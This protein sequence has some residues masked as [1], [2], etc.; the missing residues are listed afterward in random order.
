MNKITDFEKSISG[1]TRTNALGASL[2][3]PYSEF[4]VPQACYDDCGSLVR[5]EVAY[6]FATQGPQPTIERN[7][8]GYPVPRHGLADPV[9]VERFSLERGRLSGEEVARLMRQFRLKI[10]ALSE[11]T[12]ITMKHIREVRMDGLAEKNAIRDWIQAITG[13]D[14]CPS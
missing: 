12:G 13:S 9:M 11:R 3:A 8:S 6:R 14:L 10:R 5:F 2:K 1:T 7:P 4:E